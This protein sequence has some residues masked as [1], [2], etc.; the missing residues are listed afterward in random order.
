M[1]NLSSLFFSTEGRI[2]RGRWW[3]GVVIFAVVWIVVAFLLLPL[4]GVSMMPNMAALMQPGADMTALSESIAGGM[5][6]SAWVSLILF[7]IL[8]YPAY[9]LQVKRRHD[10]DNNGMDVIIYLALSAIVLLIQAL[11][12]GY[13]MTEIPGAAGLS[14][15][16]PSLPLTI[17]S[18][19]LGVYAIY[20]LVVCG[21]LRGTAGPNQY[22]PDPLGGAAM[23]TA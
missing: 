8:A 1:N 22:G 5:R 2:G 10:R 13:T 23:A 7:L 15:P 11:G 6:T 12:I 21:F 3:L 18:L 17:L 16:Q 19:V 14:I 4:A 20:L 9:C